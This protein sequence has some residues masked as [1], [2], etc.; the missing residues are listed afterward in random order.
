MLCTV[1][2]TVSSLSA[3]YEFLSGK[4]QIGSAEMPDNFLFGGPCSIFIGDSG[5]H[6]KYLHLLSPDR[7]KNN[8]N[9]RQHLPYALAKDGKNYG[10]LY[11]A[12]APGGIFSRFGYTC[13]ELLDGTVFSMYEIGLGKE[14]IV[15]PIYKG[16][17]II[18]EIDKGCVVHN[19]LD[20]YSIY[21]EDEDACQIAILL[22]IYLDASAFANR[23]EI[24]KSGVS[25]LHFK[26]INKRLIAK[27][28]PTFKA[29]IIRQS[30]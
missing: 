5:Y 29:R 8:V 25:N 20:E 7:K 10:K 27:Y 24:I 15:Y 28:D 22:C 6:L 23:G 19:N 11:N 16:D 9:M 4:E 21:A 13:L 3:A 30:V 18:A 14:G 17:T 12:D 1:K 2:Q 26:T